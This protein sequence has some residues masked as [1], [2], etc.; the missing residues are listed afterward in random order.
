VLQIGGNDPERD[1]AGSPLPIELDYVRAMM[2]FLLFHP[3]RA[4]C[5]GGPGRGSM[6]RFIHSAHA[7]GTVIE[8]DGRVTVARVLSLS[9]RRRADGNRG[10]DGPRSCR[11]GSR[12]ATCSS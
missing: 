12:A 10:R 1:A 9:R 7:A 3:T 11:S 5:H 2:A 6:A 8:I 4:T